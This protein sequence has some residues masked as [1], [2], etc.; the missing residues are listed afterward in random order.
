MD[1]QSGILGELPSSV[2]LSTSTYI[3][4][5]TDLTHTCLVTVLMQFPTGL[6][7]TNLARN[8]EISA[9]WSVPSVTHIH[10][11]CECVY[12]CILK[13][14]QTVAF[15]LLHLLS[16]VVSHILIPLETG[17]LA[18]AGLAKRR[19]MTASYNNDWRRSEQGSKPLQSGIV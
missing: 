4:Y 1:C 19:R 15:A 13:L 14:K 7:T 8:T 3:N 6:H 16:V 5:A 2:Q 17:W 9:G 12:F 10:L 11:H 18:V